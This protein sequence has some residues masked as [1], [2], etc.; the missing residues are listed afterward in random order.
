M[1]CYQSGNECI[2]STK[3]RRGGNFRQFRGGPETEPAE[4][5]Y[6]SGQQGGESPEQEES[7]ENGHSSDVLS[8]DLRNPSDA[9]QILALSG[10]QPQRRQSTSISNEPADPGM[11]DSSSAPTSCE[12]HQSHYKSQTTASIFD[13]YELVQR[14]LLR[15]SVVSELL[16]KFV[17]NFFFFFFFSLM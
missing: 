8:M 15:P 14:G 13:D 17:I 11:Q 5:T 12:P 7:E 10:D 3:S 2:L 1:S 16:F 4:S 6:I 9:L